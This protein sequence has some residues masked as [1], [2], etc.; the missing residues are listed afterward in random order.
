MTE[1]SAAGAPG[2]QP[3]PARG[4][5]EITGDPRGLLNGGASTDAELLAL[6]AELLA[7]KPSEIR[8]RAVRTDAITDDDLDRALDG[9]D[10][11][12]TLIG[13]LVEVARRN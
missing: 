12:A 1:R 10:M 8:K 5:K 4:L 6:Y 2:K 9:G 13:L 11:K 3:L 7:L